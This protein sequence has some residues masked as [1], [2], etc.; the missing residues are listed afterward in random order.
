MTEELSET[1]YN[2]LFKESISNSLKWK[3]IIL[4]KKAFKD[5]SIIYIGPRSILDPEVGYLVVLNQ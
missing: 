2:D 5:K 4:M 3:I 1:T